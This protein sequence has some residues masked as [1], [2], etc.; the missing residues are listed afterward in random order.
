MMIQKIEQQASFLPVLGL[1]GCFTSAGPQFLTSSMVFAKVTCFLRLLFSLK[2]Y[3]M[4]YFESPFSGSILAFIC[5]SKSALT[6]IVI[7]LDSILLEGVDG[8]ASI[9]MILGDN[10]GLGISSA[11]YTE[12]LSKSVYFITILPPPSLGKGLEMSREEALC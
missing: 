10:G 1:T 6:L 3:L 9:F 2:S 11:I 7:G 8:S 5:L 4:S 12:C